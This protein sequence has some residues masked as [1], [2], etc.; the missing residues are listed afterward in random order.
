MKT[1]TSVAENLA[2]AIFTAEVKELIEKYKSP[3]FEN[4]IAKGIPLT[5]LDMF[6]KYSKK[7]QPLRIKYRGTS[8]HDADGYIYYRRPVDYCHKD[9]AKSFAIYKR[10]KYEIR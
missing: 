8:V 7:V 2:K 10:E 9:Y 6:K 4:S 5:Y 1:Y 3:V